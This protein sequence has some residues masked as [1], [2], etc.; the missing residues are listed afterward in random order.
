MDLL[1]QGAALYQKVGELID[2]YGGEQAARQAQVE[3]GIATLHSLGTHLRLSANQALIGN[4]DKTFPLHWSAGMTYSAT[5][6]EYVQTGVVPKNRSA[7]AQEFLSAMDSN[8]QYFQGGFWIWRLITKNTRTDGGSNYGMYQHTPFN[9]TV[10]IGAIVKHESGLV[11]S[12]MWCN[13]LIA[14]DRARVCKTHVVGNNHNGY[15][16]IHPM[17]GGELNAESSVL[18]ALPAIVTGYVPDNHW[19]QYR[20]IAQQAGVTGLQTLD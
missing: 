16:H 17:L 9:G 4:S 8:T 14:G 19:G 13:G 7:L 10:T 20:Y 18:V 6:I 1:Q 11:P 15:T 2:K 5:P 12:S 3:K